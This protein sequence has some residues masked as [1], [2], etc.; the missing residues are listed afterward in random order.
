M[1]NEERSDRLAEGE[2][3]FTGYQVYDRHYEKIGK[4]D[5][6]FVDENDQPEYLGVKM[7]LLGMR[8]T[9]IPWEL[10][11]VNDKRR[12]VEVATDKATVKEGPTF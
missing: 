11:R 12:L 1:A 8:S 3:S 5:D 9:L 7:G 2:Y 6:L 4:V 10:V